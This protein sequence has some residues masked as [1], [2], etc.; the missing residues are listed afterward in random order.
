MSENKKCKKEKLANKNV[1]KKKTK[2][3]NQIYLSG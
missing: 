1:T 3:K 2:A